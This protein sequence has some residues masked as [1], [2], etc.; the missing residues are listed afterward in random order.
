MDTRNAKNIRKGSER[1]DKTM[2]YLSETTG[3]GK[4]LCKWID[5]LKG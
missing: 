2:S 5:N 4:E 1:A 3:L